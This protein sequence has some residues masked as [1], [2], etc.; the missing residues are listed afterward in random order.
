MNLLKSALRR[1]SKHLFLCSGLRVK[2]LQ[3]KYKQK[4]L[5]IIVPPADDQ[6]FIT[7]FNTFTESNNV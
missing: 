5:T 4:Q 7:L 1:L 2:A 3:L 6:I